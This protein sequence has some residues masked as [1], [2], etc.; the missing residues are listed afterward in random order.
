[1]S[2]KL[3]VCQVKVVLLS[4]MRLGFFDD[5]IRYANRLEK[6]QKDFLE[7]VVVLDLGLDNEGDWGEVVVRVGL[8]DCC[9]RA[10]VTPCWD[11]LHCKTYMLLCVCFREPAF[12]RLFYLDVLKNAVVSPGPRRWISHERV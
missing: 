4:I 2:H 12:L 9:L 3:C 5:L 1:M 11:I 8:P 7:D 10:C 6:R